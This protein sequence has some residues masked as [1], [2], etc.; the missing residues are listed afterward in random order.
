MRRWGWLAL[1]SLTLALGSC[2]QGTVALPSRAIQIVAAEP[3]PAAVSIAEPPIYDARPMLGAPAPPAMTFDEAWAWLSAELPKD[4]A[5]LR[6][7]RDDGRLERLLAWAP[8]GGTTTVF[9]RACRPLKVA[10]NEGS[11]DGDVHVKTVVHD[12]TKTVSGDTIELG[13]DITLVC[14]FDF[15]YERDAS[16]KW[17]KTVVSAT[18]CATTIGHSLSE[19]TDAEAWYGSA[20]AR[21]EVKCSSR[22]ETRQRCLDGTERTCSKCTR[23]AIELDGPG[24]LRIPGGCAVLGPG[25][26]PEPADC[27]VACPD[28]LGAKIATVN[29][30]LSGAT[31]EEFRLESHPTLFRTRSACLAYRRLHAIPRDQLE[32]W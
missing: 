19:V 10:R 30:A 5:S 3:A 8:P 14:G 28:D 26:R 20:P 22:L 9:D 11:L 12:R 13:R 6:P 15:T 7:S 27:A 2:R 1:L 24:H 21:I 32:T 18:G 17:V 31:F 23:V 4:T 16:G 29:A 25:R